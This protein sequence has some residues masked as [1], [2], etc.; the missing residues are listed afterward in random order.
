MAT[1]SNIIA[2]RPRGTSAVFCGNTGLAL[3]TDTE[4]EL[5]SGL[6]QLGHAGE[7]GIAFPS[8]RSTDDVKNFGGDT[9]KTIQSE[10][11]Q[12]FTVTLMEALNA[13]VL[14]VVYGDNNVETTAATADHGT[15][16][17]V[18]INSKTLPHKSWV[19]DTQDGDALVRIVVPDG[20]VTEVGEPQL[21]HS[22]V[23]QYEVTIK[24]FADDN[25][26]N[27]WMYTDDGVLVPAG[28]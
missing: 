6:T 16:N 11:N 27:A 5:P 1:I 26:D 28:D 23:T 12:T 24:A 18:R 3:P 19:F 22:G 10:F 9:V 8:E 13:S 25:G 14:K 4:T 20:Q 17:A 7:D 15:R 2:V 21:V